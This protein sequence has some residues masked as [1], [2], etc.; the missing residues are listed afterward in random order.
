MC[1]VDPLVVN[2]KHGQAAHGQSAHP[3]PGAWGFMG[4]APAHSGSNHHATPVF[5]SC[6]MPIVASLFQGCESSTGPVPDRMASFRRSVILST[7]M[8]RMDPFPPKFSGVKKEFSLC[9]SPI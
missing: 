1:S 8:D 3:P 7:P 4:P 9:V 2:K 6:S 5:A